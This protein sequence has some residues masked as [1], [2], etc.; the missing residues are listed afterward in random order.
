MFEELR[1]IGIVPVVSIDDAENALPLAAALWKGG[2][3]CVEVTFRTAA[4]ER[5]IALIR[6]AYPDMTILAGTVLNKDQAYVAIKA[7]ADVIVAPGLNTR[8]AE[9]CLERKYPYIPGVCT[10][11]EIETAMEYGLRVLKFFPAKASGGLK[12]LEALHAPYGD[13]RFMPTGGIGI[14][15]VREYLSKDYILCV[16][17]SWIASTSLI[18]E[19]R[20]DEIKRCAAEASAS[21]RKIRQDSL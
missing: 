15:D 8:M 18:S 20:F 21:V 19:G 17:G 10:P 11:S 9:Y 4:A 6:N 16:G 13:I 2:L 14:E 12:M 7:G 5:S 1:K 3:S